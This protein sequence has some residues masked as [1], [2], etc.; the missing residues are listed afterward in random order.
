V[1]KRPSRAFLILALMMIALFVAG[2]IAVSELMKPQTKGDSWTVTAIV[3]TNA[4]ISTSIAETETVGRAATF[5]VQAARIATVVGTRTPPTATE[6]P[7]LETS[8]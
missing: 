5:T 4:A 2:L 7:P 1:K 3:E 8:E 6:M